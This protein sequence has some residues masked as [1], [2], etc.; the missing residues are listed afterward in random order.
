MPF[1]GVHLTCMIDAAASPSAPTP[2]WLLKREGYRKRDISLADT[3][4]ISPRPASAGTAKQPALRT[5]RNEEFAV[6]KR[7]S[8]AGAKIL[9]EPDAERFTPVAGVRAQ[10]VSPQ[11]KLIDDFLFVTTARSIHTC[12]APSPAATLRYPDRRHIVSK[13]AE[14]AGQPEQSRTHAACGT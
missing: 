13:G 5:G 10:A 2:C 3:L 8:A 1:L 4:E 9:P 14:P 11:G 6:Q 12:N 7:L